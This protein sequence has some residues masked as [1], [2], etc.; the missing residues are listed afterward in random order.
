MSDTTISATQGAGTYTVTGTAQTPNGL[1][2]KTLT[3]EVPAIQV[4]P[5]PTPPSVCYDKVMMLSAFGQTPDM[6]CNMPAQYPYYITNTN[7]IYADE[8]CS[9]F[10]SAYGYISDTGGMWF[11]VRGGR[12]LGSGT[13][14]SN[15]VGSGGSG[16]GA[17]T[18]GGGDNGSR[19][20]IFA[21]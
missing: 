21:Q 12:I 14:V 17:V 18:T 7:L 19:T 4:P 16:G 10:S 2:I 11:H 15:V 3:I 5:P 6:V 9:D 8:N 1:L 13:C 20:D